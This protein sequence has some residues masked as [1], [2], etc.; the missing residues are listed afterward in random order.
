MKLRYYIRY[1][2]GT[3]EAFPIG[4]TKIKFEKNKD[5]GA[6]E[7]K[8]VNGLTFNN[9][10]EQTYRRL[11]QLEQDGLCVDLKV[12][13]KALVGGAY[14]DYKTLSLPI[15][16]KYNQD[17]CLAFLDPKETGAF[18][19]LLQHHK[20]K[21]NLLEI[22]A[23]QT[24][25]FVIG[26]IQTRVC[27]S[28]NEQSFTL[29]NLPRA[30]CANL[31]HSEGWTITENTLSGV[32]LQAN[33]FYS[34]FEVTSVYKR[35]FFAGTTSPGDDWQAVSGGFV[36]PIS[37]KYIP[38]NAE[39]SQNTST[40]LQNFSAQTG[41]QIGDI[42]SVIRE[43]WSTVGFNN[44][45][46]EI[47]S[48]D[49]GITLESVFDFLL[50]NC[51]ITVVSDFFNIN[52]D[53]TSPDNAAY[54]YASRYVHN[55]LIFQASDVIRAQAQ[56]NASR[57]NMSFYDIWQ[58]LKRFNVELFESS[59][60]VIRVEHVSYRNRNK[61]LNLT[62]DLYKFIR[63]LGEYEYME[64][65]QPQFER[66]S[67][68]YPTDSA[69]FDDAYI[70]YSAL[71][72]NPDS[73]KDYKSPN[74][75]CNLEYLYNNQDL[76]EDIDKMKDTICFISTRF[77][78]VISAQGSITKEVGLNK[79]LSWANIIESLWIYERPSLQGIMNDKSVIFESVRRI[80]KQTTLSV[81]MPI[82]SFVQKFNPDELVKTQLDWCEIDEATYD[83][84]GSILEITP[85]F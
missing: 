31:D 82:D 64:S 38:H 62:G 37:T 8:F 18:A 39:D 43:R 71:C 84:D 57:I 7:I 68:K 9:D 25:K 3:R 83:V 70:E 65:E 58:N 80:R 17:K 50:S 52:A 36:R 85:I 47:D 10:A 78:G 20:K 33:G 67:D 69:D 59:T 79:A 74:A 19:C 55:M 35:E 48:F 45:T 1:I 27:L 12:D 77:G 6:F 29:Y 15:K 40:D 14:I 4:S 46:N 34:A 2:D 5:Y 60:G 30:K 23:K 51:G 44:N 22:P 76:Y 66:F 49:N 53:N 28:F 73:D 11:K 24:I 54:Q 61:T 75:V 41:S 26:E 13:V 21:R 56:F 42:D 72:S 63:G 32:A 16:Q 81:K